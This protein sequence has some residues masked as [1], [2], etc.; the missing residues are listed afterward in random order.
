MDT[1]PWYREGLRF[2][3]TGCGHCCT[4]APGTVRVSEEEAVALAA[5]LGLPLSD[6]Y[7]R[8]TRRLDDGAT[9][10]IEK[11]NFECIFWSRGQ[12][13]TVYAARPRQCRTWPFWRANLATPA[14]W[15]AAAKGCPG[16][17]QGPLHAA[18]TIAT[19][20]ADDGTSGEVPELDAR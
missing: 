6:F 5:H 14:H 4:G 11:P 16:M 17:D 18:A 9:S 2:A 13:C 10:L 1:T 12:G 8:C 3:C 15:S 7:E 20:A 19:A